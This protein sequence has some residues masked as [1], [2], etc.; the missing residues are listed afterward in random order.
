MAFN[1][2]FPTRFPE[3]RPL[4]AD[5]G[6][7]WVLHVK[8]NCE[9]MVATYLLNRGISY[10]LPM[11]RK[12]QRMGHFKRFKIVEEPLFRGYLCF[13]LDKE[14]HGLLYDTKKLV[15]IIQ[16]EDQEKFVQELDAIAKAA[17]HVEDLV[18]KPGLVPGKKVLILSGPLEGAVGV[19][20]RRHDAKRL[21]LSVEMFNQTVLVKLDPYTEVEVVS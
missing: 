20:L 6:A 17:E 12:R 3:D 5:L 15:R 14:S 8:P 7:W 9:K 2:G 19:V 16:V 1:S 18:V 13:A 11:Y 10:F 21:A 4:D